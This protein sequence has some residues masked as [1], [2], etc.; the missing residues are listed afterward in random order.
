MFSIINALVPSKKEK[1]E[2]SSVDI[3]LFFD[4][5]FDGI[6][7]GDSAFALRNAVRS[8]ADAIPCFCKSEHN[9]VYSE[10]INPDAENPSSKEEDSETSKHFLIK[11]ALSPYNVIKSQYIN[12]LLLAKDSISREITKYIACQEINAINVYF[13]LIGYNQGEFISNI[14]NSIGI[15]DNDEQVE[16]LLKSYF[17]F[18][19]FLN[20]KKIKKKIVESVTSVEP[21]GFVNNI[22]NNKLVKLVTGRSDLLYDPNE[23]DKEG[24]DY[25]SEKNISIHDAVLMCQHTYNSEDAADKSIFSIIH[26][27]FSKPEKT[28]SSDN[29][30]ISIKVDNDIYQNIKE[31]KKNALEGNWITTDAEWQ[32]VGK[33]G[34]NVGIIE[35]SKISLGNR[36]TG[37]YSK[38]YK[39]VENN[40]IRSLA[41]C[42]AGTEPLSFNDWFFA[43]FLQGLTGISLQYTQSV[44]NS[45]KLDKYCKQKGIPLFFVGHSLGGGLA[46]NNALATSSRHAITFNAAG[47]N[48]FRIMATLLINNKK[49]YFN[50]TGRKNRVHPFIIDGEVVQMLRFIGEPAMSSEVGR[51]KR[52]FEL[53]EIVYDKIE[54]KDG[55]SPNFSNMSTVE[56]HNVLNFLRIK[57]LSELRID[58]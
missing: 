53:T 42:T 56:K 1:K 50:R 31:N 5:I 10:S 45:T 6:P 26:S 35:E 39:K 52:F 48:P 30:R 19:K 51:E 36:L 21:A 49:D 23:V 15:F 44:R 2:K 34:K 40:Q 27:F 8:N 7:D 41:Y 46:S 14:V 18:S 54:K 28:A 33:D 20:N 4:V 55:G 13:Y 47:L 9:I 58:G 37:F 29:E 43:N 38:L 32:S 22:L 3:N 25:P 57:N 24:K 11:V 12:Q 16:K 17:D